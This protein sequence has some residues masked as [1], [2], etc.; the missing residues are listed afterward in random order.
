[1]RLPFKEGPLLS[2]KKAKGFIP[3]TGSK[4]KISNC[5]P[6]QRISNIRDQWGS[7][8]E[9]TIHFESSYPSLATI[10]IK[11]HPF[12]SQRSLAFQQK[13]LWVW[14]L[15]F[16]PWN[17]QVV[18]VPLLLKTELEWTKWRNLVFFKNTD[19]GFLSFSK[20]LEKHDALLYR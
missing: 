3:V 17:H 18:A 7:S 9:N 15:S 20:T 6:V 19:P 4:S 11:T 10:C 16:S 1:M 2:G 8:S 12:G 14:V 5:V 13:W